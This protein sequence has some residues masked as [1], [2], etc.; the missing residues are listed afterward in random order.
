MKPWDD[1]S[2]E[3]R[4]NHGDPLAPARGCANGTIIAGIFWVTFFT[5]LAIWVTR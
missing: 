2:S 3:Y 5:L 4:A 1:L